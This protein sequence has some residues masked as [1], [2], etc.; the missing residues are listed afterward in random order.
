M[1]GVGLQPSLQPGDV[2]HEIRPIRMRLFVEWFSGLERAVFRGVYGEI[3]ALFQACVVNFHTIPQWKVNCWNFILITFK[4]FAF[5]SVCYKFELLDHVQAAMMIW[6]LFS[7]FFLD[8]LLVT[9]N[10]LIRLFWSTCYF[11][12]NN[13]NN[14][15]NN[16]YSAIQLLF[17]SALQWLC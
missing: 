17:H 12:N 13:N 4:D 6:V 1:E 5:L 8:S 14:N 3:F 10:G 9:V 2:H 15:N 16:L 7:P 11:N